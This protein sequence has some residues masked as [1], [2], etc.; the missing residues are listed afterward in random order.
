MFKSNEN[1]KQVVADHPYAA[2]IVKVTGGYMV[3]ET[4]GAYEAW[5]KQK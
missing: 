2:K 5:K 1:R 3:F 4:M